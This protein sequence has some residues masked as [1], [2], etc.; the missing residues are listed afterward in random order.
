MEKRGLTGTRDWTNC[1]IVLDVPVRPRAIRYGALLTGTGEAWF[2]SLAVEIDGVPL[3]GAGAPDLDT[4]RPGD[5]LPLRGSGFS[6][7]YAMDPTAGGS[8]R[9]FKIAS[10]PGR[11]GTAPSWAEAARCANAAMRG[12][13]RFRVPK[14]TGRSRTRASSAR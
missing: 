8:G 2:D 12:C 11:G 6:Y 10:R 14:W 9:S 5:P 1:E 13:G 4:V 3:P 7:T